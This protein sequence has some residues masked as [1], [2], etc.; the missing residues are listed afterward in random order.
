MLNKNH[1][2]R[3]MK[4]RHQFLL[5]KLA[6]PAAALALFWGVAAL[7]WLSTSALSRM[8]VLGGAALAAVAGVT[9]YAV[10]SKGRRS[11]A[12]RLAI[13]ALGTLL[14]SAAILTE[15]NVQVEGLFFGL[16]A[17]IVQGAV[18]HYL[19]AKIAGPLVF[20]RVWCG[21]ACWFGA[22]FDLLPYRRGDRLPGKWGRLRYAHLALSLGL[23]ALL[24]FG[25]GRREGALGA[26][27]LRWFVAGSLLYDLVGVALALLLKDN[28][29]FCKYLC[30]IAVPLKL[31]SRFALLK[32][33]GH[34]LDRC[35]E[36]QACVKVCP[37]DVRVIDY[38]RN[39]ERVLSTECILCQECITVCDQGVLKLSFGLDAGGKELLQ[40]RPT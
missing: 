37:M 19:I 1:E 16:F 30:P 40:T 6:V 35:D 12:R 8:L 23:V 7:A 27:A 39:G 4:R 26:A 3:P 13:F 18:V 28:R 17:G 32:V 21:W 5:K 20:G 31:T 22:V 36:D 14:F 10:L 15:H 2:A 9:L 25:F 34:N 38:V 33:A 11:P 24:W 29:A